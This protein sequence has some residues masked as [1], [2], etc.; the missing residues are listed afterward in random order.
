MN[1]MARCQVVCALGALWLGAC[2]PGTAPVQPASVPHPYPRSAIDMPVSLAVGTVRTH[3]FP[4]ISEN[5]SITL[6]AERRFPLPE[7]IC[8]MGMTNNHFDREPCSADDPLLRADWTVWS[9]GQLVSGGSSPLE[10]HGAYPAHFLL[11][12]LGVFHGESGKK[13]VVELKFTKDGSALNEAN[14]HLIVILVR[15]R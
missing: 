13:Y 15:Y 8:M 5:Y 12:G 14:P 1:R 10:D 4:V 3:E 11:K 9:A 2:V 6:Q 7:M